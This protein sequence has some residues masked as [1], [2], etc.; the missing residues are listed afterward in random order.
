MHVLLFLC[1]RLVFLFT[2]K[3]VKQQRRKAVREDLDTSAVFKTLDKII[4]VF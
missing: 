4:S 3:R 2:S 1:A